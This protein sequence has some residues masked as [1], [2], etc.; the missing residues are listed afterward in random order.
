MTA[1]CVKPWKGLA[2]HHL[3]PASQTHECSSRFSERI[4]HSHTA[5]KVPGF[6]RDTHVVVC[7]CVKVSPSPFFL[8]RHVKIRQD[9]PCGAGAPLCGGCKRIFQRT[10]Q[11][12]RENIPPLMLGLVDTNTPLLTSLL[13]LSP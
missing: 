13:P 2:W 5:A 10:L 3:E 7:Q 1:V 9:L 12:E 4:H 6:E 8:G 11:A